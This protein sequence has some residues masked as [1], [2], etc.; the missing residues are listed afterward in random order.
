MSRMTQSLQARAEILKLARILQRD[1]DSL[2][3]LE[4]LEPEDL[5]AL[6]DQATEVLWSADSGFLNRVAAASKLLPAG[7]SATISERAFGPVLTSRL[8]GRLEPKRA[9]EVAARLSTGFLADVAIELDPRQASDV[10]ARIP[11]RRVAEITRELVSRG[12]YVTMGRFVGH[13]GDDAVKAAL[14]EMDNPALL[15]I[16]FVLEDKSRLERLVG[17]L[18]AG[19]VNGLVAAAA[20]ADLWLEALDLLGHLSARRR[21]EIVDRALKLD[22]AALEKLVDAV[23]EHDLWAEVAVIAERDAALQA[24][25]ADR[26][27]TLPARQRRAVT[28]WLAAPSAHGA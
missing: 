26:L 22:P 24:M 18:A 27:P 14:G 12:E 2:A 16:G 5:R 11:P 4:S 3:Y 15:R 23:I 21:R 17:L 25:L 19:R 28:K 13:L 6:R 8:A 9:V 1:P 7:L 20:E 10:I